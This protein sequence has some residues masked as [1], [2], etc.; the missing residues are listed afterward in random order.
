MSTSQRSVFQD[1]DKD[2]DRIHERGEGRRGE[3][4][5]D[6]YRTGQDRTGQDRTG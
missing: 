2:H 5:T 1:Q 4:R 6:R 3:E